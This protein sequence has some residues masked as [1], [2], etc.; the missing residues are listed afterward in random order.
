MLEFVILRLVRD[1]RRTL[2]TVPLHLRIDFLRSIRG[3]LIPL[4]SDRRSDSNPI[5]PEDFVR[6]LF[7]VRLNGMTGSQSPV[8]LSLAE[9]RAH[10]GARQDKRQTFW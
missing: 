8:Q 10:C 4:H 9:G 1:I 6:V 2:W 5:P 7:S 3:P